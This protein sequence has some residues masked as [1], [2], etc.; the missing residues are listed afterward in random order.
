SS[1]RTA[2]LFSFSSCSFFALAVLTCSSFFFLSSMAFL[3]ASCCRFKSSCFLRASSF[4]WRSS[5]SRCLRASRA[6]WRSSSCCLC[7]ASCCFSFSRSSAISASRGAGGGGG[8]GATVFGGS[9]AGGGA[10]SRGAACWGTLAQS[11][12]SAAAFSDS[13]FQLMPQVS[14]ISSSRWARIARTN[15][16]QRPGCG[17]GANSRRSMT[18]AFMSGRVKADGSGYLVD[19]TA[20]PTRFTP[21]CCN[22]SMTLTTLSYLT[23]RSALITTALAPAGRPAWACVTAATSASSGRRDVF[24]S[25]FTSSASSLPM[26]TWITW[27]GARDA[28]ATLGRSIMLGAISGAVTMKMINSTSITSM[29]GTMLI[30]LMVRR[31]PPC[32]E[33]TTGMASVPGRRLGAQVAVQNIGE[34]LDEG[35]QLDGHPV[36]VPG[37]PVVR[38]HRGNRGEQADR[39]GDQRFGDAGRHGSQGHRLQ[40]GQAGEG[41]DGAPHRAEQAD[42]G[43]NRTDRGQA[44]KGCFDRV[45]M[46]LVTGPHGAPCAVQQRARV[47]DAA[48]AQLLV[49]AHAAGEDA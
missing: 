7:C 41:M 37:E 18:T 12:A 32:L 8:V 23:L 36:D 47:G 24:L 5:S 33:T 39:G 28:L 15:A 31:R 27:S 19:C 25:I 45:Q 44:R 48:L 1:R 14:A 43:R 6:F 42:L 9:G 21:A 4:F 34:L 2:S 11:S 3:S 10:S 29:N 35:L 38:D 40:A 46:A 22:L 30:S 16:R 20:S 13:R 26:I 17:G 49:L